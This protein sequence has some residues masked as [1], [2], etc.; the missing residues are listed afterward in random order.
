MRPLLPLTQE[1]DSGV[2]MRRRRLLVVL[3]A[4]EQEAVSGPHRQPAGQEL[5]V[6]RA[7][8]R[9]RAGAQA[10]GEVGLKQVRWAGNGRQGVSC[11]R[12][13]LRYVPAW[14]NKSSA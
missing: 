13:Q 11:K 8:G 6:L 10:R 2:Q 12:S 14:S 9:G 3:A 5:G 4:Q 7:G 1:L